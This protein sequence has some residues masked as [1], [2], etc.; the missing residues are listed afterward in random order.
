MPLGLFTAPMP[1]SGK[2]HLT[3][4]IGYLYGHDQRPWVGEEGELRKAITATLLTSARP[5]IVID[6]APEGTCVK[7]ANLAKLLTS[8][9][10]N[11]RELGA[12]RN[13]EISNDRLWLISGNNL[14]VG[15]DIASRSVLVHLDPRTPRPE[16]RRDFT[17]GQF[18]EWITRAD[19]RSK[20]LHSLLVMV[21]DW[22]AAGAPRN[23]QITMRSFTGWAA[24]TG[25]FLAHHGMH[26]FLDNVGE[27]ARHDETSGE[28]SAFLARWRELYDSRPM[29]AKVLRDSAQVDWAIGQPDQWGG[30]F[31]SDND[32]KMPSVKSL[33]RMLASHADRFHG[34]LVI[35]REK[36]MA[37][38]TWT[39]W[40]ES[41]EETPVVEPAEG[42][43]GASGR[44]P[45]VGGGDGGGVPDG[46]TVVAPV[47]AQEPLFGDG[48]PSFDGVVGGNGHKSGYVPDIR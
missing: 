26:Y 11:D 34:G 7:S 45:T 37:T 9:V 12:S 42:A 10:W 21:M 6:N 47:V 44:V 48:L 35:R 1:A 31:L 8:K 2:T 23:E 30:T 40:V 22:M 18:D 17:I 4:A 29:S 33:G 28:Y 41:W 38:N 39:W 32:G 27:L 15:G 19:N 3:D 20:L 24:K 46:A 13:R 5:V 43:E 14:T 36:N 16:L 25:G